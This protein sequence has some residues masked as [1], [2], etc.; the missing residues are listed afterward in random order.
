L[1]NASLNG[2]K[3]LQDNIFKKYESKGLKDET[4]EEIAKVINIFKREIRELN[5]QSDLDHK[6]IMNNSKT[7][8]AS[9]KIDIEENKKEINIEE[10]EKKLSENYEITDIVDELNDDIKDLSSIQNKLS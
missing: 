2:E 7:D 8:L 1:I 3:N 4:K 10:L 5:A 6:Y 9:L